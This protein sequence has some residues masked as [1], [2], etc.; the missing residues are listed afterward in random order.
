[1][2]MP[3]D[4]DNL[5][6]YLAPL[7]YNLIADTDSYKLGHWRLYRK[8]TTTV[9]S[10]IESRGGRYGEVMFAGLQQLLYEKLGQ[11]ITREQVE[12]MAAFVPAHGLPFNREG[13][14]IILNEYGGRLPLLIKSVPEGL[15]VPTKNALFSIENLDPRLPWLT[16]YLETM[17]LRDLWTACTIAT[18]IFFMTRRI[19]THWGQFSDNPMS[20]FALLDFSSRGTMGYD[21]SE[22]GGI[23]YLF[24][25]MGSDNVPAVRAANYYYFD[26]M[27]GHSVM[28]GEHSISCSF[29]RDNDDDYIR[30]SLEVVDPKTPLSLVGDSWD[31]FKFAQK[32]V[33][34]HKELIINKE[35]SFVTRPDSGDIPTVLPPVFQTL[36]AGFGTD[37]N[38][39]GRDVIRYGAK[40]LQG[41]GMNEDT[42]MQ[43]FELADALGIAPDSVITAAGGGLM[44]ADLDRDV[45]KW[46]MKASE[47]II[48]GERVDI[49]K[50][51]ITDPGKKS[52]RGRFGLVRDENGAFQT[53]N[54]VNDAE[55]R[56]DLIEARFYKGDVINA[57]TLAQVRER[58]SAQL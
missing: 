30:N 54:R 16:S 11:P 27:S 13:W 33:T 58:V 9:Y 14:E 3:H 43:P 42:H 48:D 19:N 2:T 17:I 44:T 10:Y 37:R 21:H 28:A 5:P 32:V 24:H 45:N 35:I 8:G 18:R 55:D 34:N 53:I 47:M 22:I 12:E 26:T 31:I 15:V 23:A 41:D 40:V 4:S 38:A 6:N 49:Y 7:P 50:D 36:A 25:F 57:S 51:P 56:A 29:G 20:P 1:M 39:K 52:K 46:A